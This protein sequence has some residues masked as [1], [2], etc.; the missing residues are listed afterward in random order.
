MRMRLIAETIL[1]AIET[2]PGDAEQHRMTAG[3]A[4]RLD[5]LIENAAT[6]PDA[7]REIREIVRLSIALERLGSASAAA[8]ISKAMLRNPTVVEILAR[9]F[10]DH[11]GETAA[12]F[13]RFACLEDASLRR[14]PRLGAATP[15]N[16][17]KASHFLQRLPHRP[18]RTTSAATAG[19]LGDLVSAPA[20]R[21]G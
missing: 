11:A 14:A 4:L 18:P 16:T 8:E 5:R 19:L 1:E 3:G 17:E 9:R 6:R 7:L 21:R 12:S 20:S 15:S 10:S 13:R 2:V